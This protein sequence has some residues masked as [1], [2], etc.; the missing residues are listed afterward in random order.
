MPGLPS[1]TAVARRRLA[2]AAALACAAAGLVAVHAPTALAAA[3][4]TCGYSKATRTVT[5]T[6]PSDD[7]FEGPY[8]LSRVPRTQHIGMDTSQIDWQYC[9]GSTVFNTDHIHVIGS[10]QNETLI[11]SIAGGM[12][13]PGA[14]K[15]HD[16]ASEIEITGS[17]GD[18][19]DT[20][21]LQGG[22]GND[23]L[24][25]SSATQA[26][27]TAD[28]DPDITL[29]G[30]DKWRIEGGAGNDTLSAAGA[31]KAEIV[32]GEGSDTITG[33]SGDDRIWGDN[34]VTEDFG[35]DIISAG[36][37]DDDIYAGDGADRINGGPDNDYLV[38]DVGNDVENG[39]PDN[40]T[41]WMGSEADGRDVL[42]G[43][44]GTDA[45]AY[46]SR[47]TNLHLSV[48]GKA[49][50][51][52]T[53]ERDTIAG[54]MENLYGGTGNDTLIGSS[55]G[56]ALNGGDGNDTLSGL[57]GD[58][59]LRGGNGNDTLYGGPG[60]EWMPNDAGNDRIYGQG[61][62][63]T[64]NAGSVADGRDVFSGGADVDTIDYSARTNPVTIDV[65]AADGD[66]ESGENDAVSADFERLY[67]G[68]GS[69][70][71]R[72]GDGANTIYGNNGDD[73][74][75]GGRGAD[76][77]NGGAG[78]DTL[79]GGEGY[80][81]LYGGDDDDSLYLS[82]QATDYGDGGNGTDTAYVDAGYESLTNC[83][84]VV[85]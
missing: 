48:D 54:D 39:G 77:I 14:T 41:L 17:L 61:G 84:V 47:T 27:F 33:S 40:D 81:S 67:G 6:L 72:S 9:G 56:N 23:H 30:V 62:D 21:L 82:D 10:Q 53:G 4:A 55:V 45:A 20:L 49:N 31:P 80:D 25:I 73:V 15:E 57:A 69:D 60:D 78:S 32:G 52:A 16:S 46:W 12:L 7:P 37:G 63:D 1:T 50:D 26:S 11:V 71:I 74:L 51:G 18:G 19:T 42:Q 85:G 28:K 22:A 68:S 66:G 83:E 13:G 65:T 79:T 24:H 36:A 8:L 43:G 70:V 75:D 58:D 5:L 76:S 38:G 29:A 59:S 44:P 2:T 3:D 64:I 35:N 34:G